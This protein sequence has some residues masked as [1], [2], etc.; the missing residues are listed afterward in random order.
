M[1]A[2]IGLTRSVAVGAQRFILR[3]QYGKLGRFYLSHKFPQQ[4]RLIIL[5]PD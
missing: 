3:K 2:A 5:P 4:R 1:M